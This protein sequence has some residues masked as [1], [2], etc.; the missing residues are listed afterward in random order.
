MVAVIVVGIRVY[1]D[2]AR[3]RLRKFSPFQ[4]KL[5]NKNT[6]GKE[7]GLEVKVLG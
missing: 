1:K 7:R 4:N 5:A 2:D 6:V 3:T